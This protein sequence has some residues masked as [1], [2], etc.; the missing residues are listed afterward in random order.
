MAKLLT[1]KAVSKTAA[2][3]TTYGGGQEDEGEFGCGYRAQLAT[4]GGHRLPPQA[5]RIPLRRP[6][7]RCDPAERH[8]P[9]PVWRAH[10]IVPIGPP[11]P[12]RSRRSHQLRPEYA[13]RDAQEDG[14]AEIDLEEEQFRGPPLRP[15]PDC[16]KGRTSS[17]GRCSGCG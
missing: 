17:P 2:R 1:A 5:A 14:G 16:G 9:A 7:S 4:G 12:L 10:R 8:H 15:G 6:L 13:E 3:S 11:H